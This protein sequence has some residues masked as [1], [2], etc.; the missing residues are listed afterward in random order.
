MQTLTEAGIPKLQDKGN[1][2]KIIVANWKMNIPDI[3]RWEKFPKFNSEVVIC[4]PF[5]HL[6]IA[7]ENIPNISLGAQD[8][9]WEEEGAYTGEV[10]PELLD[11][12]GV[13][14]VIIGHSERRYKMGETDEIVNKKL[15]AALGE[16]LVAILC[17]GETKDAR[18]FGQAE[19]FVNA[20]IENGLQGVSPE[21]FSRLIV[22]YEPVWSISTEPGAEAATPEYAVDMIR[23]IKELNSSFEHS[24]FIYG[25]SVTPEN[26]ESFLKKGDIE[27]A[28][29]GGA[30]LD[31]DKFKKIIE[32][33]DGN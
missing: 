28:L 2:G 3:S 31:V 33:A 19:E 7:K 16:G 11:E 27:G 21:Y 29:V 6:E 18:D 30:S 13:K 20:Q 10:S 24:R 25:G 23:F 8:S 5:S 12:I 26:A 17:V 9:F 14:Y 15:K 1:S 32:T 22:A 4:P